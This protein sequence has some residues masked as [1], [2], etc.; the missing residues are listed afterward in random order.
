M[1]TEFSRFTGL[2]QVAAYDLYDSE[3]D[4]PAFRG[5]SRFSN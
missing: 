5:F 2:L 4:P 1:Y 3:S